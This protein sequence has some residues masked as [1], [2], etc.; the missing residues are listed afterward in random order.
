MNDAKNA[1]RIFLIRPW[2]DHLSQIAQEMVSGDARSWLRRGQLFRRDEWE[3][4][5]VDGRRGGQLVGENVECRE[6]ANKRV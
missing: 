1:P 5:T 4:G 6:P 2:P 3:N